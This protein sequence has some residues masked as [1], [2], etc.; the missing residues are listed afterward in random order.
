MHRKAGVASW[1]LSVAKK[2]GLRS[3]LRNLMTST[4]PFIE[5]KGLRVTVDRVLHQPDADTPSSRPY[6]FAYYISIWND[7]KEIVTIRGRKWVVTNAAGEVTAVEGEGVVGVTP[8][9]KPGE[10]FSYNSYHLLDTPTGKAEGSYIGVDASGRKVL[11]R[12]PLFLMSA[13]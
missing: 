4:N 8:Q 5:P 11:T 10:K 2:P 3:V 12:I 13:G 6:C 1:R 9:I 7:T